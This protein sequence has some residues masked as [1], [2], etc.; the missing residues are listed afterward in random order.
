M[1]APVEPGI[2]ATGT[3]FG[4]RLSVAGTAAEYVSDPE[5]ALSWGYDT[6]HRLTD[7]RTPTE[8]AAEAARAALDG[9]GLTV[10]DVDLIV[11][12]NSDVP[13]YLGWDTSAAVAKELGAHATPTV[14]VTQ[15]C[16]AW[17]LAVDH[18]AGAMAL[19][20]ETNTALVVVVNVVSEQHA[21]R[22]AFNTSVA[23]DG[24]VAVVLRRGHARCRRLAS[25]HYTN[26]EFANLFRIEYGGSAVPVPPEGEHNLK[27]DPMAAVYRHV[28]RD[29][30]RFQ[31]FVDEINGRLTDVVDRAFARA[32]KD[33]G[34]LARLIFLNDNQQAIREAADAV[35][36]PVERTNAEL[37]RKYG[38]MGAVDQLVCL[39][40][41]IRA[42]ELAPGDLVALAGIAVPGMHWFC[43]LIEV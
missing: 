9:A 12:G 38:H 1:E 8:L 17:S 7:G 16:A 24:A 37:A 23:S 18:A 11:A 43:T 28:G 33:R 6:Y 27:V 30:Q 4:E 39:D 21:N 40:E 14:L 34:R 41:H 25:A 5:F 13:E 15:A 32:G 22:M 31:G 20:P 10:D 29:P 36:L 35:G 42:G 19:S 26:P 3:A 2:V